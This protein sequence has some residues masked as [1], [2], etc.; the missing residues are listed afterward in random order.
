MKP[1]LFLLTLAL[2]AWPQVPHQHHPPADAKEYARILSD[3]SRDK[4]QKPHEVIEA[5]ALKPGEVIAD[6]GSG[7]GYFTR[8]LAR[9]VKKV[10]AVDIDAK[11][12]E[13]A[14]K[15]AP[16]NVEA[17]L[18]APDDPRLPDASVDTVFF[19]NVLHHIENRPAYLRKLKK[20]LKPGGRVVNIDFYKKPLPVGPPVS[21]KLTEEEVTAEFQA[22]GFQAGPRKDFLPYQYFLE[23]TAE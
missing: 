14:K 20:A 17:V 15:D 4:W 5:L 9:H 22:A 7:S 2:A 19:C 13:I 16:A 3:P 6:I 21:M 12:L 1:S 8:R 11:L 18:A 23:F 10:Y